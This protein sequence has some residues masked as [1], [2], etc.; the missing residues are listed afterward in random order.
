MTRNIGVDTPQ[1]LNGVTYDF[2][3]WSDGGSRFH[4]IATPAT[5]K[6]YVANFARRAA[7]G[8]ITANPNPIQLASGASTGITRVFWTSGQTT[9]VE[10]HRDSPSGQL[11][12]ATGSGSFSQLT[13]NW[14]KEGTKL[15]LQDVSNGQPLTS[16]FTLD[17]VTLHVTTAAASIAPPIGSITADPN[18]LITNPGQTTLAWTSYGTSSVEIHINAPNGNKLTGSGPGSFSAKTGQWARPGMTFYLQNTSNGLALTA[19]NTI[20]TVTMIGGIGGTISI[21]PTPILV[22]D[23]S[24]LGVATITCTSFGTSAVQVRVDSPSGNLLN[25]S[26]PGTFSSMTGKWVQNGQKFYLQDVSDGKPLTSAN[27]LAVA[28]AVVQP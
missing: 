11:F 9:K 8:T 27:T 28:T 26:G 24:G 16:T 17:S 14:V 19:A 7:F 23:G 21:S 13:G 25:A 4:D 3:S 1:V 10:V 12:A 5:A 22:T 20:A 6:S 2:V 18:P 15:F